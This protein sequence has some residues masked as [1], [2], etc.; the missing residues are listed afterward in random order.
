MNMKKKILSF[1]LVICLII[2]CVSFL[3]A[4]I[5]HEH[6][7]NETWTINQTHHWHQC[8]KC[9]EKNDYEEHNW[10]NGTIIVPATPTTEGE[11]LFVCEDC[12][13]SKT[14]IIE[15]ENIFNGLKLNTLYVS[16]EKVDSDPT[17]DERMLFLY[18]IMSDEGI[19]INFSEN[20]NDYTFEDYD[21]CAWSANSIVSNTI[22]N[23]VQEIV[24]NS[25]ITYRIQDV[26]GNIACRMDSDGFILQFN[27][28]E[29]ID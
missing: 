19:K 9:G 26:N 10:D 16:D 21:S 13:I 15:Y 18:I 7:F 29:V 20:N 3:T 22:A 24:D 1:V 27:L 12:K 5:S 25:G 11:K 17:E 28:V 23:G 8:E 4:C 14:E 6:K 2:P